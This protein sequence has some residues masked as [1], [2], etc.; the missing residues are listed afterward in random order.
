MKKQAVVFVNGEFHPFPQAQQLIQP[1][2]YIIAVDGGTRHALQMGVVPHVIIGDLD[3]L[4][5]EALAQAEAVNVTCLRFSPHKDETDLE[6]ALQ[7]AA[8]QGIRDIFL[9]GASGGRL[10][11]S[12]ANLL[13]LA[14]PTFKDLN[15]KIVEGHQTTFLIRNTANIRG[16]P[17]DIVSILPIGGNAVG[18]SNEGLEWPL[19]DETLPTGSPR[20]ISNVLLGE[21]AVIRVRQ[22]TLLCIVR[23]GSG[24]M[25]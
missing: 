4:T 12:L 22:G 18:V 7:H 2:T 23:R 19:N 25:E 5:S 13:L 10:D 17:G 9:L 21:H 16:N 6:L 11:H 14:H 15:I 20:G 3:S 24:V 8:E 1:D